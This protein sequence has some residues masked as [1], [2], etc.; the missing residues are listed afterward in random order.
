[1]SVY[2]LIK[3]HACIYIYTYIYVYIYIYIHIH[4]YNIHIYIYRYIHET[5]KVAATGS[6]LSEAW[7]VGQQGKCSLARIYPA[8][9]VG[10]R[11]LGFRVG[12]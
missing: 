7:P 4:N 1:M 3:T 6:S 8:S 12:V 2:I 9:F 11:D 10:F 5:F